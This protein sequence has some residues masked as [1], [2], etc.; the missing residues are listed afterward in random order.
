MG[1]YMKKLVLASASYNRQNLLKR[2]RLPFDVV[3]ADIDETPFPKETADDHVKRLSVEKAMKVCKQ[4]PN[5]LVIASDQIAV[6]DYQGAGEVYFSKATDIEEAKQQ[7]L[8]CSNSVVTYLSGLTVMSLEEQNEPEVVI[9]PFQIRF[10][11][12]SEHDIETYLEQE[13]VLSCAGSFRSEGLGITL[14]DEFLGG[15]PST[16]LGFPMLKLTHLL[17]R[18][19]YL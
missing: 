18:R 3:P 11:A 14:A 6:V 8:R 1:F 4:C 9:E 13:D 15:D 2:L 7:L 12:L 5:A 16:L 17:R 10:R 19:G